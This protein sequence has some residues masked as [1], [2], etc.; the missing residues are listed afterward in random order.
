MNKELKEI[1]SN[2]KEIKSNSVILYILPKD[3]KQEGMLYKALNPNH[4]E[5]LTHD[6]LNLFL[7]EQF[8]RKFNFIAT[9]NAVK[10]AIQKLRPN[11]FEIKPNFDYCQSLFNNFNHVE[12]YTE[13]KDDFNIQ[14]TQEQLD[15][16]NEKLAELRSK[17]KII[18]YILY[19][20][21]DNQTIYCQ[22]TDSKAYLL[23]EMLA[24]TC[25]ELQVNPN[26]LINAMINKAKTLRAQ[27]ILGTYN[28]KTK[29]KSVLLKLAQFGYFDFYRS[30]EETKI[31]NTMIRVSKFV[32]N[33]NSDWHCVFVESPMT[34]Y[35][36]ISYTDF[37]QVKKG[38][39]NICRGD[40]NNEHI[41]KNAN[42][43]KLAF[44][45]IKLDQWFYPSKKWH[46]T[47]HPIYEFSQ[48]KGLSP[49]PVDE[50]V[51]DNQAQVNGILSEVIKGNITNA[52]SAFNK[53]LKKE[54]PE[55]LASVIFQLLGTLT[56]VYP[57][58]QDEIKNFGRT[59]EKELLNQLN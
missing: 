29:Q 43:L 10:V 6:L 58:H 46:V 48:V 59:M 9:L 38:I 44:S 14:T 8:L 13:L 37:S 39:L 17:G 52:K 30:Y 7:Q 26:N 28:S 31:Q 2:L 4:V 47:G 15:C 49:L 35:L 11:L 45:S 33:N 32:Q 50:F 36:S 41:E 56:S 1:V 12:K 3:K 23:T 57:E 51:Q 18:D 42:W 19:S 25:Q 55:P 40:N 5:S 24:N 54:Y 27:L 20:N 21:L 53:G 34:N 22:D 16:L